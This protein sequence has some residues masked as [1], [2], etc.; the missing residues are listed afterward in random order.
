LV[1]HKV[2]GYPLNMVD[3]EE[4]RTLREKA[5]A[6]LGGKCANPNCLVPNGYTDK[7]C[8]QIDHINGVWDE[9]RLVGIALYEDI[10][11]NPESRKKYQ[12]LC[13]NCNWIKRAEKNENRGGG[14]QPKPLNPN[15]AHI[16][17]GGIE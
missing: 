5:M 17:C 1:K 16:T 9:P 8:L 4:Q 6:F 3:F 2:I 7:R 10:L 15:I 13:A 11:E 12:I 14:P